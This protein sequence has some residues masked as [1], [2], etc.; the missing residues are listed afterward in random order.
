MEVENNENIPIKEQMQKE[1]LIK[2]DEHVVCTH[3]EEGEKKWMVSLKIIS[4]SM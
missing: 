2:E 3:E 4:L 1:E